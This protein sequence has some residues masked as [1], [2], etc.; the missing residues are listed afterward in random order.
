MK[1]NIL[2]ENMSRF[3]TKNLKSDNKKLLNEKYLGFGNQGIKYDS[4]GI[5]ASKPPTDS[6]I[7]P[8]MSQYSVSDDPYDV[9]EELGKK[10]G[11]SQSQIE[12]AEKLIRKKY[13]K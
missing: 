9:A 12:K 11:W 7:K 4:T 1:R 8:H 3:G 6:T 2:A 10:Y 5:E 13:I